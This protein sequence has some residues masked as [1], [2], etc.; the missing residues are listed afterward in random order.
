VT[1]SKRSNRFHRGS[2]RCRTSC[3]AREEYHRR[4]ENQ[5]VERGPSRERENGKGYE[6]KK[7]VTAEKGRRKHAIERSEGTKAEGA[8]EK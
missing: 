5:A 8:G 6:E 2:S 3:A 7:R 4:P 1:S